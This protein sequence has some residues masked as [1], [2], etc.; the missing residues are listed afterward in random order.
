MKKGIIFVF[1]T[2]ISLVA[3]NKNDKEAEKYEA[4][5][6]EYFTSTYKNLENVQVNDYVPFQLTINDEGNNDNVEYRL[7]P[8]DKGTFYHEKIWVD[9]GLYLS[10]RDNTI[11]K[12]KNYISFTKK[13]RHDFY[14]RPLVPGSFKHTYEFQKFINGEAVGESIK[15]SIN[16]N[17]AKITIDKTYFKIEDGD[18]PTDDFLSQKEA[19]EKK[20]D[21]RALFIDPNVRQKG[22][23]YK[24]QGDFIINKKIYLNNIPEGNLDEYDYLTITQKIDNSREIVVKYYFLKPNSN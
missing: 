2:V 6:R 17:V 4:T 21:L 23:I 11:H 13:G 19:V 16:F 1:A 24:Q 3:C 5:V 22:K 10:D 20:Y 14:I 9:F 8:V 18:R 7:T 15:L 12:D